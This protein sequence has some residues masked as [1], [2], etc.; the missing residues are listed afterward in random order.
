MVKTGVPILR[1]EQRWECPNC[2]L[3]QVTHEAKPHTRFHPCRG[4][5]GLAAPM[6]PA[7]TK[8]KVEAVE[9]EDYVGKELVTVDGESRPIM[10]VETTRDDGNDV[11]VFA[12]CATAGGGAN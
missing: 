4:L 3:K 2:E 12:P 10:R 8:C 5:K 11:A 9:R 6:V 7:G 1:P